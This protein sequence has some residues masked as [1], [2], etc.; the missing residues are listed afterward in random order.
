MH[1]KITMLFL[2][3]CI[4]VVTYAVIRKT[5]PDSQ[6]EQ[7]EMSHRAEPDIDMFM[8]NWK[9][10]K[11]RRMFGSLEV[12]DLLTRCYGNPLHPSKKGAV[13]TDLNSLSYAI[14]EEHASTTPSMLE[15]KQYIF[16]I[17]S[18][19]GTIKSGDKTAELREG[20]G[21]IMAPYIK[22]SITNTGNEQLTMYIVDE[23]I[24]DGFS[25]NIEMVMKNENDNPISTNINRV[26]GKDWLFSFEDGLST[27]ISMN[28]VTY[29]PRSLVPP[30]VHL[31]GEEE[32]WFAI[33]SEVFIQIGKQR[34][35][36]PVGTAY[37]VP[38]DGRTPHSNINVTG[39]PQKLMWMRKV[40]IRIVPSGN[41]KES[42]DNVI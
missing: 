3:T 23:P 11:S 17:V 18:G 14:L 27:L 28:P 42:S 26:R 30:H 36:F 32:V 16:Y 15:E 4:V 9:E 2:L 12:W 21:V 29:V 38:A 8:G 13:L 41:K 33:D 5:G 7:G 6:N 22:F 40:P 25:P 35:K 39:S 34:R 10:T 31:V 20:V 37:K 19:K 24:P 1:N